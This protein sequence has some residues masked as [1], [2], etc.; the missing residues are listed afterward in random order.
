[1]AAT[2]KVT[3]II[4]THNRAELLPRAVRSVLSQ[5]YEDYE[6]VI[7]DDCSTDDMQEAVNGFNDTRVRHI[8]HSQLRGASAARNTGIA[9]ARGSYLAFLDD[10]DEWL[11]SKLEKQIELMDAESPDIGLVC[12][13]LEVVDDKDGSKIQT[14]WGRWVLP[15]NVSDSLLGLDAHAPTSTWLVRKSAAQAVDG[16]DER[17]PRR[18]DM[19]FI[20]R[21]ALSHRVAVLPEVVVIYHIGHGHSRISDN[22]AESMANNVLYIR[23]HLEKF[24]TE[25]ETRPRALHSVLRQLMIAEGQRRN[26]CGARSAYRRA[27]R[28]TPSVRAFIYL[29]LVF[30][31][32][33]LWYGTPLSH[34]RER[35]KTALSS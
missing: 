32:V 2:P 18:N 9:V 3:V 34:W 14:E 24:A 23:T 27:T 8:R 4:P 31:K 7:V 25:L 30:L 29:T 21:I 28:H 12:G 33:L 22:T 11:P 13:W 35:V 20:C 1:M 19:D 6:L 16:F 26:W 5:T 17:L 10:D 15:G